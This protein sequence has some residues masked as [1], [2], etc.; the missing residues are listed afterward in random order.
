MSDEGAIRQVRKARKAIT[1]EIMRTILN[2]KNNGMKVAEIARNLELSI[3]AVY[4]LIARCEKHLDEGNSLETLLKK[5][6]RNRMENNDFNINLSHIVITDNSLTQKGIQNHLLTESG[7]STSQARI[8]KILK[9]L[10]LTRKRIK[11]RPEINTNEKKTR[12]TSLC[13]KGE[14]DGR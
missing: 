6:G 4:K 12:K 7:I 10:R 11:K 2:M 14:T 1:F 9:K 5:P 8:S 13:H 3:P